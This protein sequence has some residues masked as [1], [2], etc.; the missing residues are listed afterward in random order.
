MV[1]RA[2]NYD[3]I[4]DG[5]IE[6][7]DF[8]MNHPCMAAHDLLGV[9]LAPIQRIVFRDMWFKDYVIAICTRGY[10][11]TFLLGLV[12]A[13]SCMLIPG[14]RV[15]LL[16]P[17]YRQCL[18]NCNYTT[19]WTNKGLKTGTEEFYNSIEEGSSR[20]QSLK[21]DNII[22]NKW[23]NEERDCIL[24]EVSRGYRI[25]GVTDH[26]VMVLGKDL[27]LTY[28]KLKN[29]T[30][31]DYVVLRKNA[32]YFGNCNIIPDFDFELNHHR[33][34]DCRIPK[35]LDVD[36]SYMFGLLVGDGSVSFNEFE[37]KKKKN[38]YRLSFVSGDTELIEN[39][40]D[41]LKRYFSYNHHE[42]IYVNDRDGTYEVEYACKKLMA[43]FI[44]CGLTTTDA[45]DKKI[46]EVIK[47]APKEIMTSFLSGLMD[48]DGGCYVQNDSRHKSCDVHLSTVSEQM[49]RE[50]H[51][52]LLNIGIV[53]S[54]KKSGTEWK[55]RITGYDN[56]VKF[57]D[58]VGF[59]LERKKKALDEY[60]SSSNERCTLFIPN[61]NNVIGSL[62]RDYSHL[63]KRG[64]ER[65]KIG[66]LICNHL[67]KNNGMFYDKLR[68]FIDS[69]DDIV[70]KTDQRYINI[71]T[72]LESD[73]VFFKPEKF[74]LFKSES[75]DIE[76]ENEHCYWANG[77][78]NH[79][80]KLIFSEVERLYD[81]SSIL[82]EA[83]ER[84]PIRQ[85]DT[86][87]LKFKSVGGM[88]PSYIEALPLGND[89]SKIRGSRFYLV[90]IDELAQVPSEIIDTVIRPMGAT[91]LS[92][93]ERVRRIE[94]KNKL[95]ALGLAT[96]SDFDEETVNKMIMT[97]SGFYKFNHMWKRMKDYWKQIDYDESK[98]KSSPY[99]VW[100]IPYWDLPEG[101][102]DMN[103]VNE[104]KRVMSQSEFA[105]EYE[106]A[107]VSDSEGFFKASLLENCSLNSGFFAELKGDKNA[108]YI[109]GVDPNQGGKA[110]CGLVV[111]RVGNINK[112]VHVAELKGKT[113]QAL[114]HSIQEVCANFN[115]IR[116]FMDKGG[117]GKAVC[118]L[119][120]EGH[121]G[122]EP[123]IDIT[124]EEHMH[125]KGR[126]ILEMVNFNTTWISDA[127]FT[128]KSMFE[129]KVLLFP[130]APVGSTLELEA[131]QYNNVNIL[132]SQLLSIIV[133]QTSTGMLHFD[134]PTKGQNKD[135]YSALILAASGARKIEK[136]SEDGFEPFLYN[137][138]GMIR[139]RRPGASFG[140]LD[141]YGNPLSSSQK[142]R[143]SYA[144]LK[145][146][147]KFQLKK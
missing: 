78:I 54:C 82:R 96:E 108:Q 61:I 51:S 83:C 118:D 143:F 121:G 111:L 79:N 91:S 57:R 24:M 114:T 64:D 44:H 126:H 140:I 11:K 120:E 47:S 137:T 58:E 130:E 38:R 104:A 131:N 68:S 76:V 6:L 129:N 62:I 56:L 36:L 75:I 3:D 128:T 109:V 2:S 40:T 132:K 115:V 86:C 34:K 145:K 20:I 23:K 30:H 113:T 17:V 122:Y 99:A 39:F 141:A 46:P 19:Y 95:I 37:D 84:K 93:M 12:S 10:G 27:S 66:G 144:T 102:L 116:I 49:A 101:F 70:D 63:L 133:T 112:I 117:G 92:P 124:N 33:M 59:R 134:T 31:N 55:V 142:S 1:K 52:L 110:S 43:F 53:S 65:K 18:S 146:E 106:A 89:G 15:G 123:I 4:L 8:Y 67:S 125:M 107:M 98:G 48:T 21:S 28:K 35:F 135:L 14:Y 80:S 97:S 9:D 7:I 90:V 16:S 71:K 42:S 88:T 94:Q 73:I 22:L 87:Y 41:Y 85:T 72:I 69:I 81:R 60:I 136:E 138:G 100:Q 50:V 45:Y 147:N 77:F 103:N 119:L 32:N 74:E 5:G 127:N 26:K 13:L 29:I 139:E 105:M 25:A